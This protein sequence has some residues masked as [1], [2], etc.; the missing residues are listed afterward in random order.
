VLEHFID[1]LFVVIAPSVVEGKSVGTA[2]HSDLALAKNLIKNH[3]AGPDF[4]GE[5]KQGVTVGRKKL[6]EVEERTLRKLN[7]LIVNFQAGK[8]TEESFRSR[9]VEAMKSAW[10]DVFLAGIR[11]SGTP[12][13]E[14][15]KG[16]LIIPDVI[17]SVDEGWL[18]SAMS[19]EMQFLNNFL[20]SV[21]EGKG[22][23]PALKRARMY[24]D[25]LESFYNSARVIGLPGS[26]VAIHWVGPEDKAKCAGC[27]YLAEHSPFTKLNL[28]TVPRAGL[29][30]CLT[31]CRDRLLVRRVPESEVKTIT[32]EHKY[33]RDAHIR[34]LRN[35]KRTGKL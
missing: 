5:V 12:G 16:K 6:A 28:P 20:D 14:V 22:T 21:V 2:A 33:S 10:R 30:A 17:S 4:A 13:Y 35:L 27:R 1:D 8:T 11:A 18:K 32:E 15:G 9:I 3:K 34:N 19:H 7:S 26:N 24:V 25:A 23:M 29:T 31:N